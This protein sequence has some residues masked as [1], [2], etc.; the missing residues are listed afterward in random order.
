MLYGLLVVTVLQP[1]AQRMFAAAVFVGAVWTHEMVLAD[2]TG[3]AYY[4]SAAMFDLAVVVILSGISPIP[5]MVVRLQYVCAAS[6]VL[7]LLGWTLWH[8]YFAPSAY[9]ISFVVVYLIA[10]TLMIKKDRGDVGGFDMDRWGSCVH[11]AW[12]TRLFSHHR[13]GGPT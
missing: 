13:H 8:F 7:N 1:N 10:I 5:A 4:G 12:V 2:L 6:I 3:F 9:N 11:F